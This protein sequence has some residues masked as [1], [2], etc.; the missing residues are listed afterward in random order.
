MLHKLSRTHLAMTKMNYVQHFRHSMKISRLMALGSI[1]AVFHAVV[2]GLF[3]TSS[4]DTSNRLKELLKDSSH[5]EN[6]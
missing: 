3:L 2:P 6:E 4:T 1:K 5:D